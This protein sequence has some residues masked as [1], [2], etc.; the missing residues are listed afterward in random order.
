[1]EGGASLSAPLIAGVYA[2]A[3]NAWQ[4]NHPASIAYSHAASLHDVTTGAYDGWLGLLCGTT[5][6]QG[7]VGYDVPTGMGTPKGLGAV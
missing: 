6:C 4:F 3:G 7:A 1:M 5:I 2:L